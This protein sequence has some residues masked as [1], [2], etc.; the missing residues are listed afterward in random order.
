MAL[1]KTDII[2][3]TLFPW[4]NEY[5]SVSLSF[6]KEFVRQGTRVF[7]INHPYSLKDYWRLRHT[8]LARRRRK[9]LLRGKPSYEQIPGLDPNLAIAVHPPL[10]IPINWMKPG[11]LYDSLYRINRRR[12]LRTI[13]DVI[14]KYKLK[15]YIFFNCFDPYF[16]GTLPK[17]Q[18]SP[19]LN[20]YQCID[21]FAIEPYTARHGLRLENDVI[22]DADV[23]VATSSNLVKIKRHLND[24]IYLLPNAVDL[25]IFERAVTEDLP[26][27]PDIAHIQTPIIGFT[28][29]MDNVRF[30]FPLVKKLAQHHPDKTVVLVGP[31]NS[32]EFYDIGMDKVPNIVTTG[33]KKIEELP[34]YLQRFDVVLIPF[35]KNRQTESIYPLKINEYLA[36][37][38][39]VVST[40][41][42]DD[43]RSFA[44]WIYLAETEADFFRLIDQAIHENAPQKVR[45]RFR[46]AQT[47]TWTERVATFWDIVR[48]N[49][50]AHGLQKVDKV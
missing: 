5:S 14:R 48:K 10:T 15:D 26:V 3:V 41:F 6:T 35:A 28:G 34:A 19:L 43:I 39:P 32:R 20:I 50:T 29:N 45:E 33:A 31:I 7:Y 2:Y 40:S 13:R 47:N 9:A 49:L 12:V 36:A 30:D 11:K 16:V 1:E 38:K 42:S 21:D 18:F 17:D 24:N 23:V 44:K 25:T 27:P 4:E 22:R 8:P 46:V 37:G